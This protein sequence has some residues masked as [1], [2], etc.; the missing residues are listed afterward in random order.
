MRI[1]HWPMVVQELFNPT[2]RA[3]LHVL[4]R[5][6]SQILG[7]ITSVS[8]GKTFA[9]NW[10][11]RR[12]LFVAH[13]RL[14][15]LLGVST[16]TKKSGNFLGVGAVTFEQR[17]RPAGEASLRP[18][19]WNHLTRAFVLTIEVLEKSSKTNDATRRGTSW[20]QALFGK[21]GAVQQAA[22]RDPPVL[23]RSTT[24][25]CV[26]H[27]GSCGRKACENSSWGASR[28]PW[29]RRSTWAA[30][31]SAVESVAFDLGDHAR[32]ALLVRIVFETAE[33]DT[34]FLV[35]PGFS[36]T[37]V[38]VAGAVTVP[39]LR[40]YHQMVSAIGSL[41]GNSGRSWEGRVPSQG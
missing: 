22:S 28:R 16:F 15:N 38:H 40:R 37:P 18:K 13:A 35:A 3:G 11:V 21:S 33:P 9:V 7:D 24:V 17:H 5:A 19:M 41:Q 20:S 39:R 29:P 12:S 8:V 23:W 31:H 6:V 25:P 36:L 34:L 4:C 2:M 14:I 32:A 26:R 30:L 10:S 1:V 27:V